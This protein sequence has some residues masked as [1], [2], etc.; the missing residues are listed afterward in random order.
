MDSDNSKLESNRTWM[1]FYFLYYLK[2]FIKGISIS[3]SGFVK[4]QLGDHCEDTPEGFA[5]TVPTYSK[6]AF[7]DEFYIYFDAPEGDRDQKFLVLE[8]TEF[9]SSLKEFNILVYAVKYI[10]D[11]Y[12][13]DDEDSASIDLKDHNFFLTK[14][15]NLCVKDYT[16]RNIRF[17][18]FEG[19]LC[20]EEENFVFTDLVD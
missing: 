12:H 10:T 20:N 19:L 11:D 4:K 13:I 14:Y 7:L 15:F 9:L 1:K 17:G 16:L 8:D 3:G 5:Y 18:S 2:Y 6:Y